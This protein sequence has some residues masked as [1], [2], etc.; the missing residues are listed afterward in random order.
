VAAC[1]FGLPLILAWAGFDFVDPRNMIAALVPALVVAAIGFGTRGALRAGTMAGAASLVLFAVVLRTITTSTAL[2][3]HDWRAVAAV[4][5]KGH[6]PRLYVVPHDGR[7]PLSYYSGLG[8][9]N[10]KPKLFPDGLATRRVVVISDYPSIRGPGRGFRLIRTHT[11]PQHWT[12]QIYA[13]R[14]PVAL[15]PRQ[16]AGAKVMAQRSTA[17]VVDASATRLLEARTDSPAA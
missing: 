1:A 15:N 17:L 6:E 10:F 13:S 7:T 4:M 8:L 9:A 5:P 16:V 12:V 2:E 3:R 14:E 11:A